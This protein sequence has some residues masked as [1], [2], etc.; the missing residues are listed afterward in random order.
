[1]LLNL[2]SFFLLSH[3]SRQEEQVSGSVLSICLFVCLSVYHQNAK[4]NAIF[5]KTKQVRAIVAI[6]DI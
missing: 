4:K 6:N 2:L 3:R 5:S 1:M